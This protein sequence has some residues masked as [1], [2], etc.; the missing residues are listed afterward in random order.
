MSLVLEERPKGVSIRVACG[1]LGISA[2][3]VYGRMAR[4][5]KAS[6]QKNVD[7]A[8]SLSRKNCRQPRAL[9]EEERGKVLKTLHSEEFCDKPPYQIVMRLASRG[10]YLCSESTMHRILRSVKESGERR[11][12]RPAA[13]H[14][15]PRLIAKSP[16]EVWTWDVTK[17]KT[18]ANEYLSLYVVLDLYS[19]FALAW[20]ISKKENSALSK[21]L[22]TEAVQ[23]YKIQ[24]TPLTIH[25]DRGAPMT[26][27]GYLDLLQTLD[28]TAS[29][30]RPRVSNDNPFSESQFR[31][32]KYKDGFP[33]VFE[34]IGHTRQW[35]EGFMNHYNFK[36]HHSSLAGF[37][38]EQ[39]FTG[40]YKDIA[41]TRKATM[42]N[43]Y[44]NHPNRFVNGRPKIK[45]PAA[46]VG[47]NP[48]LKNDGTID[49]NATVNFPTLSKAKHRESNIV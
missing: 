30:S 25:Q 43:A 37:T 27:N 17:L 47:I 19:R 8:K 20:M 49:E 35:T 39:V 26:A 3:S 48:L 23:R 7:R 18:V 38:P 2:S 15:I 21:Q 36:H 29:H 46:W 31:T 34:N 42:Q 12:Q 16:N 44:Q 5:Q 33:G 22:M 4:E 14:A 28:I 45:S 13:H 40:R 9:S 10:E 32:L 11:Q 24:G 41:D 1:V 6:C